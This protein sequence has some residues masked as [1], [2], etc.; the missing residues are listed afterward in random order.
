[1]QMKIQETPVQ[2]EWEDNDSVRALRELAESGLTLQMSMYGGFEQVGHIGQRLPSADRQTTTESGDIVL[3]SADQMVVFYESNSWAYT[4]LGHITNKN[5][6]EMRELLG[7]GD[8]QITLSA[9]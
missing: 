4:R 5:A 3:F 8:V 7:H 2:V 6:Q 9:D 1:M